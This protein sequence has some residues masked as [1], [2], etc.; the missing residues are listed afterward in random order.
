MA[1]KGEGTG[2]TLN[3]KRRQSSDQSISLFKVAENVEACNDLLVTAISD[4]NNP[5]NRMCV[6]IYDAVLGTAEIFK[7]SRYRTTQVKWGDFSEIDVIFCRFGF[8]RRVDGVLYSRTLRG[9]PNEEPDA[10]RADSHRDPR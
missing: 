7:G 3:E 9:R 10:A 8:D 6:I 1:R 4:R 2:F 5:L